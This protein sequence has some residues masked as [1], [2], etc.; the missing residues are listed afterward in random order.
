MIYSSDTEEICRVSKF[1]LKGVKSL[2]FPVSSITKIGTGLD[3]YGTTSNII[4]LSCELYYI[5]FNTEGSLPWIY[6]VYKLDI[7]VVVGLGTF[8]A[9]PLEI[10][11]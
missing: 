3:T 8:N 7:E 5:C 11:F 4:S 1:T 6:S 2:C 9:S 10:C